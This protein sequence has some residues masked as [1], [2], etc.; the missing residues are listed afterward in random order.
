MVSQYS[1]VAQ[2]VGSGS[3]VG[4]NS[5]VI[6]SLRIGCNCILRAGSTLVQNIPGYSIAEESPAKVI[7]LIKH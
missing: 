2:G 6:E 3:F 7:K 4:I 1:E 5:A